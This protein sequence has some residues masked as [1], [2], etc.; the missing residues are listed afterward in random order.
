[1]DYESWASIDFGIHD[2][3]YNLS[4]TDSKEQMYC[5]SNIFLL[6]NKHKNIKLK[7]MR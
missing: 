5:Y 6:Y 2:R 3:S 4:P 1:M 7:W